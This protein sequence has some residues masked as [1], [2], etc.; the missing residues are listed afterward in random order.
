MISKKQLRHL[1]NLARLGLSEKELLGL[2]KDLDK[3]LNYVAQLKKVD[4]EKVEPI[5]QITGLENAWRADEPFKPP[6]RPEL[7]KKPEDLINLAP[8]KKGRYVKVKRVMPNF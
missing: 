3:I 6:L 7:R 1:A 2:K 5:S 4:T 8:E